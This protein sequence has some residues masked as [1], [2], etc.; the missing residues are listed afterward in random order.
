VSQSPQIIHLNILDTDYAKMT[1]GESIA[2]DR[3]HR[4][5]WGDSTFDHL[6]K[7]IARYRY[8]DLDQ[9]GRDDLLCKIG[10][11]AELFTR[12]DREDFNDRVRSTGTF[13]LTS[14]ERQQVVNWLRDELAVDLFASP[15]A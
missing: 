3:K 11:T 4:L 13:Y 8:D 15:G 14:G 1:A 5:A 2:S 9:E 12:S 7:Q 10:T 6:G